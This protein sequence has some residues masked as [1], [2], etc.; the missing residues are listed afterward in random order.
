MVAPTFR[1]KT[2]S[3]IGVP[4]QPVCN[5]RGLAMRTFFIFDA[6]PNTALRS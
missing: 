1:E 6:D 3:Q 5:S 4:L 2:N